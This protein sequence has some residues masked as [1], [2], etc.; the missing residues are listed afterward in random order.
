MKSLS[1]FGR[2]TL[3]GAVLFLL[4]KV[5]KRFGL[6]ADALLGTRLPADDPPGTSA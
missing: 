3:M 1:K 5:L 6:G 4:P 2:T